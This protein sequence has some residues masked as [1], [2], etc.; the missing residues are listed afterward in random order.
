MM[1]PI[2]STIC[3]TMKNQEIKDLNR[4]TK[5]S[6]KKKKCS[7]C[8]YITCYLYVPKHRFKKNC[9]YWLHRVGRMLSFFS[10]RLNWD[11]P[12][13]EP[14]V[15]VSPHPLIRGG[16]A[17]S[18]TGEGLGESQFWR[19]DIWCSIFIRTLW[20]A[21]LLTYQF[22]QTKYPPLSQVPASLFWHS[23]SKLIFVL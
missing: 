7:F 15:S 8:K 16:R 2:F 11:S 1:V 19:G 18:L 10:S 5:N 9:Q 6:R 14:Q 4:T 20:L 21:A 17:H 23:H 12:P 22:V 13:P 3:A